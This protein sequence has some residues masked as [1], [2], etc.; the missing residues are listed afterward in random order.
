MKKL[1]EQIE[2]E[3]DKDIQA[4]LRKGNIVEIIES[5]FDY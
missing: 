5:S 1:K 2:K 4:E 3:K